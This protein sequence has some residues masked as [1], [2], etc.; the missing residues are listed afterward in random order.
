VGFDGIAETKKDPYILNETVTNRITDFDKLLSD[1]TTIP[2]EWQDSDYAKNRLFDNGRLPLILVH[3]WDGTVGLITR[4]TRRDPTKLLLWENSEYN[5]WHNFLSYYLS[6]KK[7]Q[8]KYHIY[9]YRYPSY[10]HISYNAKI[11]YELLNEV[12]LD[13]DLGK[14]VKS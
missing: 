14:M 1:T 4:E 10:K 9:L 6:S 7:L 2:K 12:P 3:G 13:T 8:E 5:Y 11:F